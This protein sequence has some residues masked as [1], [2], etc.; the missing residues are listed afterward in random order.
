MAEAVGL[1]RVV[2]P[3]WMP[4]Q[5]LHCPMG[6]SAPIPPVIPVPESGPQVQPLYLFK[7]GQGPPGSGDPALLQEVRTTPAAPVLPLLPEAPE[8][9]QSHLAHLNRTS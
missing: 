3:D 4:K 6:P 9:A 7:L 2:V 5:S 1:Q 8:E